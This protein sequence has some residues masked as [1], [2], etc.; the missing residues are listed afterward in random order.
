MTSVLADT[1]A[2]IGYLCDRTKLSP[3][4]LEAFAAAERTVR[5]FDSAITLVEVRLEV[6]AG[7]LPRQVWDQLWEAA[8]DRK[9]HLTALP[10]DASVAEALGQVARTTRVCRSSSSRR[11]PSHELRLVSGL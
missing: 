11:R 5:L 6:A 3:G 10:V 4:V 1:R 2:V 9:R 7:N 8:T